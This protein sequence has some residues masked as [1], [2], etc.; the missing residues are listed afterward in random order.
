MESKL[1]DQ[2][3]LD[4]MF[5]DIKSWHDEYDQN[6][7]I[8]YNALSQQEYPNYARDMSI[9]EDDVNDLETITDYYN[10]YKAAIAKIN[11]N[12]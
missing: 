7:Q 6:G 5:K 4:N 2:T 3:K 11:N 12:E 8:W 10:M 1:D 9:F